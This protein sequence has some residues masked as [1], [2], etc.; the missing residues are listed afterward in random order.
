[1]INLPPWRLTNPFPAFYES[2]SGTAIQQTAKVYA[3]VRG[4]IDEY[5]KWVEECNKAI[6]DLE[7]NTNKNL[8]CTLNKLLEIT[9]KHIQ[10]MDEKAHHQDSVIADAVAYMKV[11]L[12]MSVQ[13]VLYQMFENGEITVETV[14]DASSESLNLAFTTN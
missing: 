3:A 1:M 10:L 13:D 6:A 12:F 4:L 8:D 9:N 5:N 7:T 2:E 14:Y 11:N